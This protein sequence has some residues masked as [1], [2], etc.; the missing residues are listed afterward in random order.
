MFSLII[1]L[2]ACILMCCLFA[3]DRLIDDLDLKIKISGILV[4]VSL[5]LLGFSLINIVYQIIKVIK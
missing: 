1:I 2:A 5:V 4:K 3:S